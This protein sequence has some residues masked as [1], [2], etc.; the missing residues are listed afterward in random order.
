MF[1]NPASTQCCRTPTQTLYVTFTLFAS[2]IALSLYLLHSWPLTRTSIDPHDLTTF[3]QTIQGR[4]EFCNGRGVIKVTK[5]PTSSTGYAYEC[6]CDDG[7]YGSTCS[8]M[9]PNGCNGRGNCFS[10]SS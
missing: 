6:T 8:A 1:T 9:C 7:Y 10:R 4:D 2:I 5:N 3:T